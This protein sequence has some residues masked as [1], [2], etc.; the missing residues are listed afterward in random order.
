M[1]TAPRF[2]KTIVAVAIAK[3]ADTTLTVVYPA[4]AT[5]DSR[6][7]GVNISTDDTSIQN[8]AFFI[9]DGVID[10]PVCTLPI[11]I[12]SGIT[13]SI[14]SVGILANTPAV[15]REKDSNGITILNLPKGNSLKVKM[16]AVTNGKFFYILVKAELYD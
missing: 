10:F 9:S 7:T 1:A 13:V 6:I 3:I 15:I 11:P 14:P 16:A 8:V 5:Y 4:N 12:G 2:T